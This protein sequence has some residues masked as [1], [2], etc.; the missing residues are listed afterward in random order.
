MLVTNKEKD[1][2]LRA[3]VNLTANFHTKLVIT[4]IGRG[5]SGTPSKHRG[6]RKEELY[7]AE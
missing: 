7:A 2:K 1:R 5:K 3:K 6:I 4:L